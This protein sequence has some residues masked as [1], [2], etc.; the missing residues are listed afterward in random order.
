MNPPKRLA[1]PF[2]VLSLLRRGRHTLPLGLAVLATACGTGD[3]S[4]SPVPLDGP[5]QGQHRALQALPT[6]CANIQSAH[7]GAPDGYYVLYAAGEA[8]QPWT[9]WCHDM[10]GTPAEYLTLEKTGEVFNFSQYLAADYSPGTSVQTRYTRLRIDPATLRVNT[11]DQRFSASSGELRH[12]GIETV[13]S[14]PYGVAM[15]CSRYSMWGKGNIDLRGTSFEVASNQLVPGGWRANS[16][17]WYSE[18][19][20]V[21]NFAGRGTCGWT[22]PVGSD[23]PF[24]QRG[25]LLQLQ[26][27]PRHWPVTCQALKVAQPSAADGAYTLYVDGNPHKPWTAWCH[28]MA[29]TPA[30]YLTLSRGGDTSNYS[31]YTAG[32]ASPGTSV[33]TAYS[34]LRIDPFTLRVNTADQTFAASTGSLTH[35]PEVVTSMPFGVAMSCDSAPSLANIDLRDTPFA[36]ADGQFGA[37][38]AFAEGSAVYSEA[39]RVVDLSGGGFCG[40]MAPVSSYNPFNQYGRPLPLVYAGLP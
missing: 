32:G 9:A 27:S 4:P 23:S 10:A 37:G 31:T 16:D 36:V 39:N 24:N 21:V 28:D 1:V 8:S 15:N 11:A 25:A 38:G 18:G 33:R 35:Y 5:S 7:P 3:G 29:G 2:A 40:W 6:T 12:Q 20:Q 17:V 14:M 13:T 19:N 26:Y 34:R 30:E 22:A